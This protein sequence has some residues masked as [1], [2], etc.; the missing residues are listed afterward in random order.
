VLNTDNMNI[1]GE[2]FDYGPWRFA[3]T[4]DPHFVAAY[5]DDAGLYA[6]GRQPAAVSWNLAQL[7]KALQPLGE[8]LDGA[9]DGFQAALYAGLRGGFLQRLGLAS[10]GD[11]ADTALVSEL[12]TWLEASRVPLD[13]FF[14]DWYGG[15]T[16]RV[17]RSPLATEY[18]APA[19]ATLAGVLDAYRPAHPERL[20]HAYLTREAPIDLQIETVEALW[21][22]IDLADDWGPLE[23]AV[24]AVREMGRLLAERSN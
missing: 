24:E 23:R 14:F 4:F 20:A 2:S 19:F 8:P 5:F 6:F 21:A 16:E 11:A 17:E 15:R 1:T 22:H 10:K 13:R 18:R 3:P 9:T 7:G 12:L